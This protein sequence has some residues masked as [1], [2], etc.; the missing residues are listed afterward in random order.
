MGVAATSR[1]HYPAEEDDLKKGKQNEGTVPE[2]RDVG[3]CHGIARSGCAN[4]GRF[5]DSTGR[6]NT[7]CVHSAAVTNP[8]NGSTVGTTGTGLMETI[9]SGSHTATIWL[10]H[11]SG[12]GYAL[13][14]ASL[15]SFPSLSLSSSYTRPGVMIWINTSD[16]A[17]DFHYSVDDTMYINSANAP[18]GDFVTAFN[19]GACGI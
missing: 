10:D 13:Y 3:T 1:Q 8:C 7:D 12:D 11:E 5:P 15:G 14:Q 17:L 19:S 9:T 2:Y 18:I 4:S 16:P 6:P